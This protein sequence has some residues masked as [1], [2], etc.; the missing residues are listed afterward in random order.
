MN[1]VSGGSRIVIFDHSRY[2]IDSISD[3]SNIFDM[4]LLKYGY[5]IRLS[6]QL[7]LKYDFRIYTFC[8]EN[9]NKLSVRTST[10]I[11]SCPNTLSLTHHFEV[12]DSFP[13]LQI[14]RA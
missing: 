6:I 12:W 3:G 14:F 11:S 9:L 7:E 5:Y 1:I 8:L 13:V 10:I 2:N 4:K